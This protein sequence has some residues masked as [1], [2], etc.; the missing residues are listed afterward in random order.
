MN[1]IDVMRIIYAF[2]L[3]IVII[4]ITAKIIGPEKKML[5]FKKRQ[6]LSFF[7][8]RGLLGETCHFGYPCSW[9]GALIMIFMYSVIFAAGYAL[10][11]HA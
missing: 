3:G 7:N 8:M 4:Y 10:I 1:E 9:Q 2:F 6:R 5:W 11:F